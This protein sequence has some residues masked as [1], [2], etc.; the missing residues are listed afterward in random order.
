ISGAKSPGSPS[1]SGLARTS[2]L[3]A[4]GAVAVADGSTT[5]IPPATPRS[6]QPVSKAPPILPQPTKST[7]GFIAS[8]LADRIEHRRGDGVLRCL[9]APEHELEGGIEALAFRDG[10]VDQILE[11]LDAGAA[12]AAQQHRVPEGQ[13]IVLLRHPE[14]AQPQFFI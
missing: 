1:R 12:G 7:R 10:E 5:A 14:M 6:S 2:L 11:L 8:C 4:K 9:P 3:A 13:E